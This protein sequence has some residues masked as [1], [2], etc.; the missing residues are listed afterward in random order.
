M[1]GTT[2]RSCHSIVTHGA[3]GTLLKT[4]SRF[5]ILRFARAILGYHVRDDEILVMGARG[6][7]WLCTAWLR[8][9]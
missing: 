2:Y 9:A 6:R 4:A 1:R 5:E 8:R 7:V 3:Y